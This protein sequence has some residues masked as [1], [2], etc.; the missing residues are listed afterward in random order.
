MEEI[1]SEDSAIQLIQVINNLIVTLQN[2]KI[3]TC[4]PRFLFA[5]DVSKKLKINVNDATNLMKQENFPSIKGAGRLKVE[6]EAFTEW[7]RGNFIKK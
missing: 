6:E 5:K 7:C 2:L 4:E 3:T 1:I